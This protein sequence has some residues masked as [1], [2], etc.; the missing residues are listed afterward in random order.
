[1]LRRYLGDFKKCGIYIKEI[2]KLYTYGRGRDA[3]GNKVCLHPEEISPAFLSHSE[4]KRSLTFFNF[5]RRRSAA[6]NMVF[7]ATKRQS[8]EWKIIFQV[9]FMS[10]VSKA[11]CEELCVGLKLFYDLHLNVT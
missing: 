1:M 8:S 11:S 10:V 6:A 3:P 5:C 2:F 4:K 9:N 7:L